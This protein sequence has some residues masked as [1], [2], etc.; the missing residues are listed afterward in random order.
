MPKTAPNWNY[1]LFDRT[2]VVV[3]PSLTTFFVSNETWLLSLLLI[4]FAI[5]TVASLLA[6][7]REDFYT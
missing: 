3:S 1:S 4:A 7:R 6:P 5:V 2:A